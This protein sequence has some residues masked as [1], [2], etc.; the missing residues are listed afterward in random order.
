[1]SNIGPHLN[2]I[3]RN[4]AMSQNLNIYDY[5]FD[6]RSAQLNSNSPLPSSNAE[7]D[8]FLT[9]RRNKLQYAYPYDEKSSFLFRDTQHPIRSFAVAAGEK[10]S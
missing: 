1:M 6:V 8:A 2:E 9:L 10:I 5:G 3:T 4:F 7:I